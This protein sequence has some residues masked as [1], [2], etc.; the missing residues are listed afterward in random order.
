MWMCGNGVKAWA[1]PRYRQPESNGEGVCVC[2]RDRYKIGGIEGLDG[3][4]Q[5]LLIK[6]QLLILVREREGGGGCLIKKGGEGS[7]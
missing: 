6:L 7:R 4:R 2:V 5:E 3:G 1:L